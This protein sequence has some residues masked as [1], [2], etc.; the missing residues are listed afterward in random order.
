VTIRP[1][2]DLFDDSIFINCAVVYTVGWTSIAGGFDTVGTNVTIDGSNNIVLDT[3]S[4]LN[5]LPFSV[6][7]KATNTLG[8]EF[9]QEMLLTITIDCSGY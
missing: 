2:S 3:N 5:T 1:V 8:T 7:V 6:W 4:P 9:E